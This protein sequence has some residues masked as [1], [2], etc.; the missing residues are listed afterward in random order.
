MAGYQ[1][2]R[3]NRVEHTA[4]QRS[5]LMTSFIKPIKDFSLKWIMP[6]I[7]VIL[8]FMAV[9]TALVNLFYWSIVEPWSN[10][11]LHRFL[12]LFLLSAA[13]V[14]QINYGWLIVNIPRI[15]RIASLAILAIKNKVIRSR[16]FWIAIIPFLG[17]MLSS[18]L[19]RYWSIARSFSEE[20]FLYFSAVGAAGLYIGLEFKLTKVMRLFEVLFILILFGSF[21]AVFRQPGYAIHAEPSIAGSWRGIFWWKSYLGEMSG[22]AAVVF[23]F[24]WA[25]FKNNRWYINAYS[26]IFYLLS[27]YVLIKSSSVTQLFALI[28]AHI[29]LIAAL[30]ISK[31]GH[32]LKAK[33]WWIL[34]L[35]AFL[36][37]SLA[38]LGRDIIFGIFGRNSTLTGRMPIWDTLL[39]YIKQ[40]LLLGYGFGEAFWRHGGN[41]QAVSQAVGWD[42]PFAHNG[43]IEVL[44][45]TG[46]I[47]LLF[48]I[49]F[50][51]QTAIMSVQFFIRERTIPSLIFLSWITYILVINLA[52][53]MLGSYENFTVLLLMIAFSYTLRNSIEM[54]KGQV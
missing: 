11:T 40:R 27:I 3:A 5:V 31:W 7:E 38:G 53:N 8:F 17:I 54:N 25:D 16:G 30:S 51:L 32:K 37:L 10:A 48:W 50:L 14:V 6:V 41:Q 21:Y 42:V 47:G 36:C 29:V 13:I 49:V 46:L 15:L 39:P 28:A 22:L 12:G 19:S 35:V 18:W 9:F 33:H 4:W 52:D 26:F 43:F 44:L 23:L 2:P 45:G 24:R 20:R 34:A 1:N